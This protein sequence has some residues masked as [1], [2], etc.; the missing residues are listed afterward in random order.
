[1]SEVAEILLDDEV[2]EAVA[3]LASGVLTAAGQEDA[4]ALSKLYPSAVKLLALLCDSGYEAPSLDAI[5]AS[6]ADFKARGDAP[7]TVDAEA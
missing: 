7:T 4:A 6:L 5:K 1:M 3:E 2:A